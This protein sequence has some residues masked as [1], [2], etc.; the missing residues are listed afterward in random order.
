MGVSYE[1]EEFRVY[2]PRAR[3]ADDDYYEPGVIPRDKEERRGSG[4]DDD[5]F[6]DEDT[7]SRAVDLSIAD[8]DALRAL[9][10]IER[11]VDYAALERTD[12]EE[13][14]KSLSSGDIQI[15]T[16]V[17]KY[18][19][20]YGVLED[21]EYAIGSGSQRSEEDIFSGASA[22]ASTDQEVSPGAYSPS[23]DLVIQEA[24]GY[25]KD[26][27]DD[28]ADEMLPESAEEEYRR[29]LSEAR[30]DAAADVRDEDPEEDGE[31]EESDIGVYDDDLEHYSEDADIDYDDDYEDEDEDYLSEE[32]YEANKQLWTMINEIY[33]ADED[34]DEDEGLADEDDESE[35]DYTRTENIAEM[36][37]YD[38]TADV[39][40]YDDIYE[41]AYSLQGD[42]IDDTVVYPAGAEQDKTEQDETEEYLA[43]SSVSYA[44]DEVPTELTVGS[45]GVV[46][47]RGENV[48][49]V[50]DVLMLKRMFAVAKLTDADISSII[51][52]ISAAE[53]ARLRAE[54]S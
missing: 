17:G 43:S 46:P 27:D 32:N 52:G 26:H 49:S 36:E 9:R 42:V 14:Y 29:A 40:T 45:V 53:V 54:L 13:A 15:V 24:V 2:S 1:D 47:K 6:D 51:T 28:D 20:N 35:D 22:A 8:L 30:G 39:E 31:G 25:I 19:R 34:D 18:L 3:D 16:G 33:P 4:L 12:P 38:D 11:K 50:E 48:L 37:A 7:P 5:D 10:E 41:G 23:D 44:E 21:N